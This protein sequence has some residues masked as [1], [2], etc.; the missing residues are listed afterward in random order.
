MCGIVGIL[1]FFDTHQESLQVLEKMAQTV[2]HRGP[3]QSGTY[4]D[5]HI[6]LGHQRLSIIDLSEAGRQPMANEDETIWIVFNGEIYNFEELRPDLVARGHR[7]RSHTDTEVVLHLYET[8]DIACLQKLRGMFA[9]AIWDSRKQRLLLARDRIGKK[10]LVYF[11]DAQGL[12][13][14]SEQKALLRHPRVSKDIDLEAIDEYL[15]YQY[16]P[17]PHTIFKGIQK[18]L[19]AHY[20]LYEKGRVE[21]APYWQLRFDSK[22]EGVSE[23]ELTRQLLHHLDEATR[24]RLKSD[25]PLGAFLSGGV[26]SS[27]VVATM[28]KNLQRPV[29]T[30]SIGFEESDYN[31]LSYARQVASL[32][33]TDHHEFVIKPDAVEILPKLVW[34][35]DEPY[36]DPSALPTYYLSSLTRN[37]AT[38]ALNGD[39]G[40]EAFAGYEKYL[41]IKLYRTLNRLPRSL[42]QALQALGEFLPESPDRRTR[43]RKL[44]RFLKISTGDL[45]SD[46]LRIMTLF[47]PGERSLLYAEPFQRRLNL[48][49]SES[50]LTQL[51]VDSWHLDWV[52]CISRTDIHSYLPNDLLVK[53]DIASMSQSLEL[54]SPFLD[55]AASVPARYKV[56]GNETKYLLK[57]SL[58][59]ILPAE[60]LSRPKMGFGVPLSH[61]F[62][63]ALKN[64]AYQVLLSE[65]STRRGYFRPDYVKSLLDEHANGKKDHAYQLWS[66]LVLEV[67]H[68]VCFD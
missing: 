59:K 43:A 29:K 56:S 61:W 14:A 25:V 44:K 52:D 9:L 63:G 31:E 39:G 41:A 40:D 42:R 3:D 2:R 53:V 45:K 57:R 17:A 16:I 15:V 60:I 32:F 64:F 67:W 13:F 6:F 30:F 55:F 5:A 58:A 22:L 66:L 20:L 36:S 1:N 65:R 11:L 35:Y 50:F 62:R 4:S 33:Q 51:I 26:D 27:A 21:V 46:Y 48:R 49:R 8:E 68:Q 18:L 19:P 10:P 37:H 23:N 12:L 38:V 47:D 24:V 28:A 7:F 34:H 54:R